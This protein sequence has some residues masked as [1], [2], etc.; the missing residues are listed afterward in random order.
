ML[1]KETK[2]KAYS[3][4]GLSQASR[5]ARGGGGED[6][7]RREACRVWIEDFS[8]QLQQQMEEMEGK[9]EQVKADRGGRRGRRKQAW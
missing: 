7:E 5:G 4:E 9:L 8:E 2:T 3:K 6:E 1:E